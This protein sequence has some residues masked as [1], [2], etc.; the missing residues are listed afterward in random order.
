[1]G[2]SARRRVATEFGRDSYSK[3]LGHCYDMALIDP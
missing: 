3:K 1:M 2:A